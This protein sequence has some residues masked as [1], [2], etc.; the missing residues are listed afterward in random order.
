MKLVIMGAPGS[1][2]GT[3]AESLSKEFHLKHISPGEIL[4]DEVV[5]G[6][7]LGKEI[8]K[9]LDKGQLAPNEFVN[10][11]V[12]LELKEAKNFILDGFP[13]A[14]SQAEFLESIAKIDSVI[15]LDVPEEKVIERLGGRR[16]CPE[17]E[18]VYHEKYIKPKKAGLCDKCNV[19]LIQRDDD[20]PAVIKKR[21]QVYFEQTRPVIRYFE[22]RRLLRK[23]DASGSPAGVYQAV[24]KA[25]RAYS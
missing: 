10:E 19:K 16:I 22:K 5:K 18:A 20:K 1:G 11:I 8:K 13:R 21:F 14:L 7:E 2:K 12:R 4:R 6:T 3:V 25:V 9:Y 15:F 23:V 24:K 17:C